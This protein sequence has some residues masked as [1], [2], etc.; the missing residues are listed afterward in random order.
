MD[1]Y[2]IFLDIDGTLVGG[3]DFPFGGSVSEG[4]KSAIKKA[5][6]AGHYVFLNT[7]RSYAWI[8]PKVI[9][10]LEFDGVISG[11]GTQAVMGDKILYE[12]PIEKQALEKIYRA[13]EGSEHSV[14]FG[15]PGN[16]YVLNPSGFL[17][18]PKLT[19]IRSGEDFYEK[20]LKDKIQ[21]VEIFETE[22]LG[23]ERSVGEVVTAEQ[24]ASMT[25]NLCTYCH[26]WYMEGFPEG[27]SKAKAM[28]IT[29]EKLGIPPK[30]TIAVGDSVNDADMLAAAGIAVAMGNAVP[31]LKDSAD[32]VTLDCEQD[33]VAYAIEQLLF[34]Q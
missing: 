20:C 18:N 2:I 33:G 10:E 9:E 7:G 6:E 32:F 3:A 21:K 28:R 25:E 12:H 16:I 34:N 31:Q 13:F 4:N 11:V 8:Q 22:L 5:R 1:R 15:A 17:D 29:A 19:F 23:T 24:L 27:C 14:L 30:R 26:G